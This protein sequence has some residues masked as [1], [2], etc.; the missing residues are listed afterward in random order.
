M[1]KSEDYN[2]ILEYYKQLT[3]ESKLDFT[4]TLFKIGLDKINVILEDSLISDDDLFSDEDDNYSIVEDSDED[5]FIEY[6][7]DDADSILDLKREDTNI[8]NDMYVIIDIDNNIIHMYSNDL[9]DIEN[10]KYENIFLRGM[11]FVIDRE[12]VNNKEYKYYECAKII[13]QLEQDICYN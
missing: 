9:K 2:R 7:P 11:F 1:E 4:N 3:K 12:Y 10:Y 13:G 5:D 8:N 6:S